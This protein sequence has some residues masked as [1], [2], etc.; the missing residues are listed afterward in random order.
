MASPPSSDRRRLPRTRK[1]LDVSLRE[2]GSAGEVSR[3]VTLDI[4]YSGAFVRAKGP[5][6][7]GSRL[8]LELCSKGRSV[9]AEAQVARIADAPAAGQAASPSG[10]G[11]HFLSTG[12][13][14]RE[15]LPHVDFTPISVPDVAVRREYRRVPKHLDVRFVDRGAAP[16][17]PRRGTTLD[18][19]PGGAF[20]RTSMPMA[21]AA[22]LRLD[23]GHGGRWITV[24]GVVLRAQRHPAHLQS[25]MPSGMAIRFLTVP[26]LLR[27]LLPGI[28]A[29]LGPRAP[30]AASSSTASVQPPALAAA[31]RAAPR[32]GRGSTE[33]AS[34]GKARL[35]FADPDELRRLLDGDLRAGALFVSTSSPSPLHAVID[36]E[37]S[38]EGQQR[39]PVRVEARVVYCE[40]SA[41]G[42][43]MG[44]ELLDPVLAI[45]QIRGLLP[46][47]APRRVGDLPGW[48][49]RT[50][51][52]VSD[53]EPELDP[54]A[55]LEEARPMGSEVQLTFSDG[56]ARNSL[57]LRQPSDSEARA[58]A[59]TLARAAGRTIEEIEQLRLSQR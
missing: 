32:S 17:E 52:S 51:T 27:E 55:W 14:L 13:V 4:S 39:P 25:V 16:A 33:A 54:M 29:E 56:R 47:S 40:T 36:V 23:L 9:A 5:W 7:V 22:R 2:P 43:G 1:H 28:D 15:L 8:S 31:P 53:G 45:D 11:V 37:I 10:L 20:V 38:V 34:A 26:E 49:T 57:V 21:A 6:R 58:L 46:E 48:P 18:I 50:T 59:A 19:S 3:G 24:E 35:R 41:A 12:E 30:V 44:V 42:A